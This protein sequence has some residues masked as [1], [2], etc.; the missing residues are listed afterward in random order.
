[1]KVRVSA[2]FSVARCRRPM[3]GSARVFARHARHD[4]PRFDGHRLID[5]AL[6]LGVVA[7]LDG[8]VDRK[9][10]AERMSHEAVVGEDAAQVRMPAKD[11]AV[12]VEGF[13]LVPVG[14]GPH[15]DDRIHAGEIVVGAEDAQA[16]PPVV[17]DREQDVDDR[18]ARAAPAA[19]ALVVDAH[20]VEELAER[21]L[22]V[23]AQALRGVEEIGAVHFER[24]LPEVDR[25]L[26]DAPA[27]G[28][29]ERGAQRLECGHSC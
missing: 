13:A 16:H 26:A 7:H 27:Q 3:C 15:A 4:F 8:A 22:R 24:E 28:G 23:V 9:V 21:K 5:H 20:H 19:V 6:L 11:D 2:S 12:E 10:L 25:L 1:M 17:L 18:E 14:R 29:G